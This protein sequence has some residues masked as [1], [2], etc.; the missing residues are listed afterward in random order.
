MFVLMQSEI[1]QFMG[2]IKVCIFAIICRCSFQGCEGCQCIAVGTL[3]REEGEAKIM[4][5]PTGAMARQTLCFHYSF[6]FI[7]HDCLSFMLY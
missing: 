4:N 5:M 1:L 6:T 7:S 2:N 3:Y